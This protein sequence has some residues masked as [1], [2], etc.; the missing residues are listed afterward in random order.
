[1]LYFRMAGHTTPIADKISLEKAMSKPPNTQRMP[2]VRWL[3]SWDWIDIPSWTIPQPKMMTPMAL[4]QEKIKSL[5]LLT[6]VR[7]SVSA[8]RAGQARAAHRASMRTVEK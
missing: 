5:R 8:A 3:A 4:I 6:I 7:G 1:M 2:W